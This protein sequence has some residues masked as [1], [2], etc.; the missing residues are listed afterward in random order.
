MEKDISHKRV[1]CKG[2]PYIDWEK[3]A[4]RQGFKRESDMWNQYYVVN[5]WGSG[6]ICSEVGGIPSKESIFKRIKS[7]GIK[8]KARGGRNRNRYKI[9]A[10]VPEEKIEVLTEQEEKVNAFIP[11]AAA[12]AEEAVPEWEVIKGGARHWNRAYLLRINEL[13]IAAGVRVPFIG[14]KQG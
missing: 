11:E 13:T 4:R 6:R 2:R 7:S 3:V 8:T 10:V 5:E 1:G 14:L 9:K 12:F